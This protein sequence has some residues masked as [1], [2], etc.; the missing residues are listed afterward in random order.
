MRLGVT[1]FGVYLFRII[2]SSQIVAF[3]SM[4]S[5]SLALIVSFGLTLRSE[6]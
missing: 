6:V 2:T 5:I 4:R 1:E 3:I